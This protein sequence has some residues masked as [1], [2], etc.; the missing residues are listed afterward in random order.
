MNWFVKND[1]SKEFEEFLKIYNKETKKG[2][3]NQLWYYG[4]YQYWGNW[5]RKFWCYAAF[6]NFWEIQK[7][8]EREMAEKI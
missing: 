7:V 6:W 1:L 8:C 2:L 4:H 5:T 3:H